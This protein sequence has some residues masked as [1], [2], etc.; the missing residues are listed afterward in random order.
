MW[1]IIITLILINTP[2]QAFDTWD[3]TDYALLG[4][5]TVVQVIDWRQTRR[6]SEQPERYHEINPV[7]G[8]NPDRGSVDLYFAA[9]WLL[10]V[11]IAHVLP[12]QW[13]KVWLGGMVVGSLGLVVHNNNIGLGVRW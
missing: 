10:K 7:I 4:T 13:R 1:W 5:M 8:R 3:R 6:I 11:G 9:S 2:A 12:S